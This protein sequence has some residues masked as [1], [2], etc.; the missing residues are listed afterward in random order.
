M[1]S[2]IAL[3]LVG[4]LPT[5]N[6]FNLEAM[7]NVLKST[8]KPHKG[9]VIQDIDDNLF[10][11]QFFNNDDHLNVIKGVPWAFDGHLLLLQEIKGPE[12]PKVVQF[13]IIDI[14]VRMCELPAEKRN[15]S[16]GIWLANKLGEYLEFDDSDISGL[17]KTLRVRVRLDLHKPFYRWK[18]ISYQGSQLWIKFKYEWL[19]NCC[20]FCGLLGHLAK[21]CNRIDTEIDEADLPCGPWLK[22]SPLKGKK[23]E[24]LRLNGMRKTNSS[25]IFERDAR[26]EGAFSQ[27]EENRVLIHA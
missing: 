13:K 2:Q 20:Y 19:P 10:F 21:A 27:T 25:L 23:I 1:D 22:A 6:N 7:K 5:T 16:C 26:L 8:W 15:K 4:K 11:F 14:W 17:T 24:L 12:Q 9:V 18:P 3:C